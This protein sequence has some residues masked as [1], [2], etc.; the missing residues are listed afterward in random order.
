MIGVLPKMYIIK[1]NEDKKWY[2]K[3]HATED[4][5]T[6]V[7]TNAVIKAHLFNTK[8]EAS[9]HIS[10]F[11]AVGRNCTVAEIIINPYAF[12]FGYGFI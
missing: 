9:D 1:Y 3:H 6:C 12:P 5:S 11:L 2:L 4:A 10:K 7:W 8:K